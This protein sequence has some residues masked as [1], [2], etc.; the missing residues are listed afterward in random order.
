MR[1]IDIFCKVCTVLFLSEFLIKRN[2]TEYNKLVNEF[3][4]YLIK[5]NNNNPYVFL[6]F[7][8]FVHV[9][10]KIQ[11]F[12]NCK[13]KPKIKHIKQTTFDILEKYKLL[14]NSIKY[15]IN[16]YQN[17]ELVRDIKIYEKHDISTNIKQLYTYNTNNSLI[18]ISDWSNIRNNPII[19]MKVCYN[20]S[21][22]INYEISSIKFLQ[23]TVTY[24]NII[25]EINLLTDKYN[26]YIVGNQVDKLFV[27][28]YLKFILKTDM[29]NINLD[30]IIYSLDLCDQNANFITIN[31]DKAIIIEKDNYNIIVKE[32]RKPVEV[33]RN[34][35][36]KNKNIE[37]DFLDDEFIVT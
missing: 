32:V 25:Y 4:S 14:D 29:T 16:F 35:T 9:S 34:G 37:D 17:N 19:N 7:Y 30:D 13:L 23:M 22:N 1:I 27:F 6:I 3:I 33:E 8:K 28:Y 2:K 24:T 18:I 11:I 26:F 12:Y 36:Q 10:S 15:N 5:I 20:D 21:T 31:Q